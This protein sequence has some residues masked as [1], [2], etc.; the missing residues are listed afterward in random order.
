MGVGLGEIGLQKINPCGRHVFDARQPYF[1][2]LRR[3]SAAGSVDQRGTG[4]NFDFVGQESLSRMGLLG[5]AP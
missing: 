4:K 1:P 5:S 3:R 2:G